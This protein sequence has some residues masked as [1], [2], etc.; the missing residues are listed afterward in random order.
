MRDVQPRSRGSLAIPTLLPAQPHK[1]IRIMGLLQIAGMVGET[2]P[3]VE[4]V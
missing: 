3:K 1:Y 2:Y 4:K